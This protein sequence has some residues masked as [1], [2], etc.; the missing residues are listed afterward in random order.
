M[1]I[2]LVVRH[3]T[4][5]FFV[6]VYFASFFTL[7]HAGGLLKRG[8][9]RETRNKIRKTKKRILAIDVALAAIPVKPNNAATRA[10]IKKTMDQ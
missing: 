6:D 7:T 5:L 2:S 3:R 1:L 10:M 9:I 4:L 8:T